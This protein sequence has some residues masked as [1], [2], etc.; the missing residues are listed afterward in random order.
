MFAV[1]VDAPADA[2]LFQ[3]LDGLP[4]TISLVALGRENDFLELLGHFEILLPQLLASGQGRADGLAL[5]FGIKVVHVAGTARVAEG[6]AAVALL[7]ETVAQD[8][9]LARAQQ[10]L[11]ET[12]VPGLG[13]ADGK[14]AQGRQVT[15]VG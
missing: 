8:G 5:P 15:L 10:L 6:L 7:V 1:L 4:V 14:F 13:A 11:L 2:H 12:N 3:A 9:R